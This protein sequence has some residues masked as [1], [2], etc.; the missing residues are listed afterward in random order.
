MTTSR[1]TDWMDHPRIRELVDQ[2]TSLTA[3]ERMTLIKGLVPA[4]ADALTVEEFGAFLD[5]LRNKD[6]RY[7][8]ALAHPGEGRAQRQVPGEQRQA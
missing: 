1:E 7:R 6:A 4:L 8:E 5:E 3:E 2:A